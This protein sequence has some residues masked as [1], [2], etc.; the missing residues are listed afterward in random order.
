MI[1]AAAEA[2]A[3]HGPKRPLI[4]AVTVLTSLNDNDLHAIGC[5]CRRKE[6]ALAVGALAVQSRG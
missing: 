3:N 2:A 4:V 5:Q 6:Q 1:K